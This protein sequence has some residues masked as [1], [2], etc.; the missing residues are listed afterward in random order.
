MKVTLLIQKSKH[1]Y[2]HNLLNHP[3]FGNGS[4]RPQWKKTLDI[5]WCLLNNETR[6][7]NESG[8][9]W[10]DYSLLQKAKMPRHEMICTLPSYSSSLTTHLVTFNQHLDPRAHQKMTF[11]HEHYHSTLNHSLT[12]ITQDFET[13]LHR[14]DCFHKTSNR[15]PY[16]TTRPTKSGVIR[17]GGRAEW[18]RAKVPW[19]LEAKL[20]RA[21]WGQDSQALIGI[22]R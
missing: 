15:N 10:N 8:T 11:S 4:Y 5:W 18:L 21:I 16:V 14:T 6:I 13:L 2:R 20:R 19:G 3:Q 7:I 22:H 17:T 12:D 1:N 9:D